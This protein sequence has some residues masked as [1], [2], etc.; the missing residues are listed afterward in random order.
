MRLPSWFRRLLQAGPPD[1]MLNHQDMLPPSSGARGIVTGGYIP[2]HEPRALEDGPGT[3]KSR[4]TGSRNL[5]INTRRIM[6]V[7]GEHRVIGFVVGRQPVLTVRVRCECWRTKPRA[8][9][10]SSAVFGLS[11]DSSAGVP[12]RRQEGDKVPSCGWYLASLLEQ[13]LLLG[14]RSGKG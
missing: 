10:D 13:V 3:R 14:P 11:S 1:A 12:A 4:E 7:L 5:S 8:S 6:I 9:L 2:G